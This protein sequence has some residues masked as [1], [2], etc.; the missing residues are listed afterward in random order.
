MYTLLKDIGIKDLILE[1][2]HRGQQV[3]LMYMSFE[4]HVHNGYVPQHKL[5]DVCYHAGRFK[6]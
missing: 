3:S 5:I 2:Y 6:L 4:L 1:A